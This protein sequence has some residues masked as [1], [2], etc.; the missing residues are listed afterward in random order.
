M[1]SSIVS[2]LLGESLPYVTVVY[3]LSLDALHISATAAIF[4][5]ERG[6]MY[7]CYVL[8][9]C[10]LQLVVVSDLEHISHVYHAHGVNKLCDPSMTLFHGHWDA[11]FRKLTLTVTPSILLPIPNLTHLM[12]SLQHL[13]VWQTHISIPDPPVGI[14]SRT[15]PDL[16]T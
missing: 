14:D 13:L 11:I 2:S 3:C 16:N 4:Q 1:L 5:V 15:S 12:C 10:N 7:W 6:L 9:K 8:N